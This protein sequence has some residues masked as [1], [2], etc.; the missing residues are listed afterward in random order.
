MPAPLLPRLHA[1]AVHAMHDCSPDA[2][3]LQCA[4]MPDLP[5][6]RQA[7]LCSVRCTLSTF[8]V[9]EFDFLAC[10]ACLATI[11]RRVQPGR[12][13][14]TATFVAAGS[15]AWWARQ[16]DADCNN[17]VAPIGQYI[18][19]GVSRQLAR[20]TDIA[21]VDKWV[22]VVEKHKPRRESKPDLFARLERLSG[23]NTRHV[24]LHVAAEHFTEEELQ[25][26]LDKTV[27]F[28]HS[29]HPVLVI[30]K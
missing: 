1:A 29:S 27:I 8:F 2:T 19:F 9:G 28:I 7:V 30:M 18:T 3:T 20:R 13:L 6:R 24:A 21:V 17:A 26:M 25:M 10:D 4:R 12:P 16:G 14:E 15:P 11:A 22:Q 23:G 5:Q